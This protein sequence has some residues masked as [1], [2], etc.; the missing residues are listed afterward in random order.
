MVTYGVKVGKPLIFSAEDQIF[1][2]EQIAEAT[3][4]YEIEII[5]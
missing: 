3:K 4:R 5:Q 2:A 1:I